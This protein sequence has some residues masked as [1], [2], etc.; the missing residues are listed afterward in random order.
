MAEEAGKGRSRRRMGANAKPASSKTALSVQD[1]QAQLPKAR[2]VYG[3]S[4]GG[5][6]KER[7]VCFVFAERPRLVWYK[8]C[9]PVSF[10]AVRDNMSACVCV[11]ARVRVEV[12]VREDEIT[13]SAKD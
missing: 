3:M 1:L 10:R 13:E 6:I 11:C 8:E 2:V 7:C 12:S 5:L 4:W 9:M